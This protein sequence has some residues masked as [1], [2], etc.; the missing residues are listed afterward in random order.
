VVPRLG[1]IAPAAL[2]AGT[3]RGAAPGAASTTRS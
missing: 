3:I 2:A 1:T